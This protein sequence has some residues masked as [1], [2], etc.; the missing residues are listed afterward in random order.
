MYIELNWTE[1]VGWSVSLGSLN[2]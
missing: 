1:A 2:S